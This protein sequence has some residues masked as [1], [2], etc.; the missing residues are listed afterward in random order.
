MAADP[1]DFL[2]FA[3]YFGGAPGW[4]TGG[5]AAIPSRLARAVRALDRVHARRSVTMDALVV[6]DLARRAASRDF[7]SRRN[8]STNI[9]RTGSRL[10]SAG[11]VAAHRYNDRRPGWNTC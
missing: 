7:S 3:S 11:I 5:V 4:C 2:H 1:T 10:Q 8:D 9:S 6:R